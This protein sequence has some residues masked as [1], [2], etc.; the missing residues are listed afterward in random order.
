MAEQPEVSEHEC[1]TSVC[2]L[3]CEPLGALPR[4]CRR[5]CVCARTLLM[6]LWQHYEL[7]T[8]VTATRDRQT[9][10]GT[11]TL[12]LTLWYKHKFVMALTQQQ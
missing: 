2:E 12:H 11:E 10:T 3:V 8:T 1:A 7:V 4:H 5:A 6:W 9:S